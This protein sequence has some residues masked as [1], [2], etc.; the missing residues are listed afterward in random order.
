MIS[1]SWKDF[2]ASGRVSDYLEYRRKSQTGGQA[3]KLPAAADGVEHERVGA[4]DRNGVIR[5][6]CR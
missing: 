3:V 6:A 4:P 5:D 2:A 1:D